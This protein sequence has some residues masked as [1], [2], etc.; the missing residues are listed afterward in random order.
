VALRVLRLASRHPLVLTLAALVALWAI[1]FVVIPPWL[2]DFPLNDDWAFAKGAITFAESGDIIYSNWASMPQL[3]QWLWTWP[4]LKTLGESHVVLRLSTIVLSLLA[5]V[6]FFDLLRQAGLGSTHAAFV[7]A[8]FGLNPLYFLLSG[9]FLTDVPSLAFSLCALALYGRGMSSGRLGIMLLAAAV[10]LLGAITRQNTITASLAAG[11]LYLRYPGLRARRD[12]PLWLLLIVLPIAAAYATHRWFETRPDIWMMKPKWPDLRRILL[13]TF[14]SVHYLGLAALP[15]LAFDA[16]RTSRKA[17]VI[18]V[19]AMLGGAAFWWAAETPLLA[20]YREDWTEMVGYQGFVSLFDQRQRYGGLFPYLE[21]MLTPW[22]QFDP[23]EEGPYVPIIMGERPLLMG[24]ALRVVLSLLGC[25]AGAGLLVRLGKHLGRSALTE[26]LLTFSA[27]HLPFMLISTVLFDRYLI[28][29]LP[30]ALYSATAP[31]GERRV[32]WKLG[33][34]ALAM[35]ALLALGMTHDWLAWNAARWEL[36]RR[37]LERGVAAT[38]VE[39]GFEWNCWHAPVP[40]FQDARKPARGLTLA[41][42]T[43]LYSHVTGHFA[44][45]FS[46][47][48]DARVVDTEPYWLWLIPGKRAFYLLESSTP[49]WWWCY[50]PRAG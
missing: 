2:H 25:F 4:F 37:A 41:F 49:W 33:L 3:G 16:V 15:V 22:G 28:V 7:A 39:G 9:T 42:T 36:G 30:G 38:D 21:N 40:A 8:C 20:E 47:R 13:L 31:D 50:S 34:A 24:A 18:A 6:A 29:L 14:T 19:L 32:R 1:I 23:L 5:V 12:W 44:L 11:L 43:F 45:S 48:P 26:P 35:S 17:L 10:A 46:V 27:F